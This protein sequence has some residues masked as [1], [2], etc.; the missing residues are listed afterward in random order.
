MAQVSREQFGAAGGPGLGGPHLR[1]YLRQRGAGDVLLAVPVADILPQVPEAGD[2]QLHDA[3]QAR[4]VEEHCALPQGE[5]LPR[6]RELVDR[7]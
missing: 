3:Q 1:I 4:A 6:K 5:H 2:P 7:R